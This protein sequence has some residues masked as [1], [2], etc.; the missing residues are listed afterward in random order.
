LTNGATVP[1]T[2]GGGSAR[3]RKK[4]GKSVGTNSEEGKTGRDISRR[5]AAGGETLERRR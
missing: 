1:L 3:G 4:K 2:D 5:K